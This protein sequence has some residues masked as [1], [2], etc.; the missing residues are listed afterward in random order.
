MVNIPSLISRAIP[1]PFMLTDMPASTGCSGT[2][3]PMRWPA[4]PMSG[5][6]SW[7]SSRHRVAPLPKRPSAGLRSST[8]SRKRSGAWPP[9]A[10]PPFVRPGQSRPLTR[11]K[12]GCTRNCRRFPANRPSLRRSAMRL[13][14][15]RRP[16]PISAT[17]IWGWTTTQ[18]SAPPNPSPL[19]AKL[20][21]LR[22]R[23]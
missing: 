9:K 22:L 20:D 21:V 1:A 3:R 15:C 7:M 13:V 2:R 11:W 10:V 4:W 12:T 8:P 6:S 14:G 23:G 5:A 16:G 18:P 19:A 17:G